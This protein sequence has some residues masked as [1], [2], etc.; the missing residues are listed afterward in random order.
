M[1]CALRYVLG[2]ETAG[3]LSDTSVK[4]REALQEVLEKKDLHLESERRREGDS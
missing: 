1:E 4:A 2:P 3:G